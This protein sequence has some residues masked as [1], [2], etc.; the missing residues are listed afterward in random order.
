MRT[1]TPTQLI[2]ALLCSSL[3]LQTACKGILD[4]TLPGKVT[5]DA[6]NNPLQA[7]V[8]ANGVV[9]DFECAWS[10]YVTATNALSDQLVNGSQ[11]GVSSEWY[12][13]NVLQD[14]VALLTNC[15]GATGLFPYATLQ[16]ARTDAS[17][18]YTIIH[19]FP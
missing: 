17:T 7:R 5:S 2:G 1:K 16:I 15:D 6:L 19:G 3:V 18:M 9:L 13:R 11:Q 10:N 4:V 14:D 8:L 12:L